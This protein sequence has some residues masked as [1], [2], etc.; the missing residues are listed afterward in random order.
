MQ[1]RDAVV[2]F[3]TGA[4]LHDDGDPA[5]PPGL[6][7]VERPAANLGDRQRRGALGEGR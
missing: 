2:G 7:V 6:L 5:R 1:E 3:D 4:A